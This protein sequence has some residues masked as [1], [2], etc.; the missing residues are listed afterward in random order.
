MKLFIA[1]ISIIVLISLIMPIIPCFN[2]LVQ[3]ISVHESYYITIASILILI[4][5]IFYYFHRYTHDNDVKVTETRRQQLKILSDQL[6]L[7]DNC[8]EELL[9]KRSSNEKELA[10]LRNKISRNFEIIDVMLQSYKDVFNFSD[11]DK[12]IIL[13]VNSFV[14][15]S[16]II[17][18][19]PYKTYVKASLFATRDQ[20]IEKTK[21]AQKICLKM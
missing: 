17:M 7:C 12:N 16:E 1:S 8:V 2:N 20:Y 6:Y 19:A 21:N 13:D 18:R 4:L 3:W 11:D 14:D 10:F 5:G 9:S 15:K